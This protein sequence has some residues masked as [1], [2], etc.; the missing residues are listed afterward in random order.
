[1]ITSGHGNMPTPEKATGESP[2]AIYLL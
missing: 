1:L 2:T